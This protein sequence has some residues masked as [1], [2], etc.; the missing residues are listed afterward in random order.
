MGIGGRDGDGREGIV[1]AAILAGRA[2]SDQMAARFWT[3]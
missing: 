2:E 1:A 3:Q